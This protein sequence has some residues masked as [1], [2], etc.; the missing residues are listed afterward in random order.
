[1]STFEHREE[2]LQMYLVGGL[3]PQSI[4]TRLGLRHFQPIYRLLKKEGVFESGRNVNRSVRQYSVNESFFA[5]IDTEEK[6]YAL[7]FIAAD[8]YVSEDTRRIVIALNHKDVDIL[9]KLK[10]AMGSD[11]PIKYSSKK[12]QS[13]IAI[14]SAIL[15]QDLVRMGIGQGKSLTMTRQV[16]GYVPKHLKRHFLRGYFDGDGCMTLGVKYSSGVKHLIQIIGTEDFLLGTYQEWYPSTCKLHAYKSCNMRC[17][18]LASKAACFEFLGLLY[19]GSSIYLA[20]KFQ[21][22]QNALM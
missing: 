3:T 5:V 15:V 6:A 1:M 13:T 7:G 14:N 18:K 12:D 19:D 8:G 4:Q 10:R 16:W 20:R 11:H 21:K 22:Y 2:I 17:W 9:E